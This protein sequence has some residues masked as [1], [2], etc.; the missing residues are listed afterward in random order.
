M[1]VRA[2]ADKHSIPEPTL[3]REAK[4]QGWVKGLAATKRAM[5]SDAMAGADLTHLLT[6]DE[7]RQNQLSAAQQ[8]VADMNSG[9]SVARDCIAALMV[10][11]PS[12]AEARE[13]KVIVEAN[14]G[15]I[16]TI[17]KIRGLDDAPPAAEDGITALLASINGTALSIK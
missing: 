12:A 10:M 16:E 8:D 6:H 9:L 13:I 17:R 3:R 2:I 4:K 14:K 5:V 1:S 11:I 15:A 7:V